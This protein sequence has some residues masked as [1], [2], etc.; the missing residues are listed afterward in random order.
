MVKY[1]HEVSGPALEKIAQEEGK[2][3]F[4]AEAVWL[5]DAEFAKK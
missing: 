4:G 2:K 1:T 5:S 3:Q